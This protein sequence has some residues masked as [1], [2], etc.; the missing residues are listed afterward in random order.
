MSDECQATQGQVLPRTFRGGGLKARAS[1]LMED[2]R[3]E[4]GGERLLEG[5][6]AGLI[7]LWR[8]GAGGSE[9]AAERGAGP[10]EGLVGRAS[11]DIGL[12][13]AT[14]PSACDM[15]SCWRNTSRYLLWRGCERGR[16]RK[17][18]RRSGSRCRPPAS[19]PTPR[20]AALWN[21]P[22]GSAAA[23]RAAAARGLDKQ[24]EI[25]AN[26]SAKKYSG[27]R[28]RERRTLEGETER[29][30]EVE[31]EAAVAE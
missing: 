24:R 13:P 20:P 30:A 10:D 14:R 19:S 25:E 9:G 15:L 17:E 16:W 5:P 28:D 18:A 31:S 29:A 21:T 8:G 3:R 1:G 7:E 26:V 22:G 2:L 12:E 11:G 23:L 27:T 4:I 6:G